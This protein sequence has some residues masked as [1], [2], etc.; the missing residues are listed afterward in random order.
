[1]LIVR[2]M[3]IADLPTIPEILKQQESQKTS[4]PQPKEET[5]QVEK[6]KFLEIT[7]SDELANAL[8]T[9]RELLLYSYYSNNL[10][11]IDFSNGKIKYFDRKG[12]KDFQQKLSV[13]L[14]EKTGKVWNLEHVMESNHTQTTSEHNKAEIESD[15]MVAEAMNLFEDAEIVKMS[16]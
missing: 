10:E 16:K 12:D 14:Q 6:P 5:K 8:H 2:L 4:A 13:W 7:T 3:H 11:I 9:S 15:P 1:M